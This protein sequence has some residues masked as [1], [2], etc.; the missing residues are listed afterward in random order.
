[1]LN[2][3]KP[4]QPATILN[5]QDTTFDFI[6]AMKLSVM[7]IKHYECFRSEPYELFGDYYIAYGHLITDSNHHVITEQQADSIL[8]NDYLKN[9]TAIRKSLPDTIDSNYIFLAGMLAYN[10]GCGKVIR[11]SL[12]SSIINQDA[13]SVIAEKYISFCN[14]NQKPHP[15][16]KNRRI[17]ELKIWTNY[18]N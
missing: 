17:N 2:Q 8:R 9:V 14:I 18:E 4:K 1:M 3:P 12:L 10:I 6:R 15:K 5:Q 16:L 13:D 11:S 7:C